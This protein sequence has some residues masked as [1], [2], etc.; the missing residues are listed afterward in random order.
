MYRNSIYIH[1][2]PRRLCSALDLASR[3]RVNLISNAHDISC[4]HCLAV[5]CRN[6][7]YRKHL[8]AVLRRPPSHSHTPTHASVRRRMGS[9]C[10][11][12]VFSATRDPS[13]KGGLVGASKGGPQVSL[14]R[15][16]TAEPVRVNARTATYSQLDV[17]RK[18]WSRQLS[19]LL[20]MELSPMTPSLSPRTLA[21]SESRLTLP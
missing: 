8:L 13:R 2:L 7:R 14:Q 1:L 5:C 12:G 4:K 15:A 19:R 6:V 17:E 20:R 21:N 3:V 18:C 11:R 9:V 10:R 16:I